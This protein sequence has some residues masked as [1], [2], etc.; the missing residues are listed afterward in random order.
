MSYSRWIGSSWYSFA[1][2]ENTDNIEDE[3]LAL[4][5]DLGTCFDWSYAQLKDAD[6][7]FILDK[8]GDIPEEDVKQA[9][10][11]IKMFMKD[12]EKDHHVGE[13]DEN[14]SDI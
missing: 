14:P 11:I 13:S 12:C 1:C 9:L 10:E 8:Y 2:G 5:Y 3:M 7:K 6:E 4:W